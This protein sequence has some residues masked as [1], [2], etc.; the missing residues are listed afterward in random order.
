MVA[1]VDAFDRGHRGDG[2]SCR[3]NASGTILEA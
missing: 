2:A 1:M 3:W